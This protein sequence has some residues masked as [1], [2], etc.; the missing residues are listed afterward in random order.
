M[1]VPQIKLG[2]STYA[3]TWSIGVPGYTPPQNPISAVDFLKQ[4]NYSGVNLVQ[5]ADNM[6]L[7]LMSEMELEVIRKTAEECRIEIEIG[8]RGTNPDHLLSYLG[9]AKRL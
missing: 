2:I 5:I 3:L 6:P 7:H 9:I 1:R 8:T 4:A